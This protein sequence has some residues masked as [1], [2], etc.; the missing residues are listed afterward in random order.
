MNNLERHYKLNCK[1]ILLITLVSIINF[2]KAN[3]ITNNANINCSDTKY[4]VNEKV[5]EIL[6][7][8]EK[9]LAAK[10]LAPQLIDFTKTNTYTKYSYIINAINWPWFPN[11][12]NR[13]S[14]TQNEIWKTQVDLYI[15]TKLQR[16]SNSSNALVVLDYRVSN[17]K[18]SKDIDEQ[19]DKLSSLIINKMA[20]KHIIIHLKEEIDALKVAKD[21]KSSNDLTA[22]TWKKFIEN[23]EY[24]AY[25]NI[26]LPRT[27]ALNKAINFSKQVLKEKMNIEVK[28]FAIANVGASGWVTAL[29]PLTQDKVNG[30]IVMPSSSLNLEEQL[31]HIYKSYGNHWPIA[32]K[33]YYNEK[34]ATYMDPSNSHYPNFKKLVQISDAF[35][36]L[37][38]PKYKKRFDAIRKG[39]IELSGDD[40]FSPNSGNLYFSEIGGQKVLFSVPNSP[41]DVT[42][43]DQLNSLVEFIDAFMNRI[44]TNQPLPDINFKMDSKQNLVINSTEIPKFAKLWLAHNP[45][46]RDFRRACDILYSPTNVPISGNQIITQIITPQSGWDASFVEL[47]FKDGLKATTPINTLPDT[48]PKKTMPQKGMCLIIKEN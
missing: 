30:I 40:F 42:K 41:H 45:I 13:Q 21:I 14:P 12:P 9:I 43:S 29:S 44:D 8:S 48:Y 26:L 46:T 39:F 38:I 36:Y 23:P 5:S 10:S 18:D 34:I 33:D 4:L 47:F 37:S 7:C 19:S 11:S 2:S 32:F 28:D 16:L 22:Y 17:V 35:M 20:N 31:L 6:P 15:P 27:V 25:Y 1:K 3:S 24:Y